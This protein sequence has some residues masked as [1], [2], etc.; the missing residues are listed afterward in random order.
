MN[1][2]KILL[3]PILG[4]IYF[5]FVFVSDYQKIIDVLQQ[6]DLLYVFFAVISWCVS[7][8]CRGLRWHSFMSVITGKI[9]F[10]KNM[11]YYF[12]GLTMILTPGRLGEIIRCNFIKKDY[13]IP[14]SKTIALMFVE[15]FYELFIISITISV[16][17][18]STEISKYLIILPVTI[19]VF[20]LTIQSKKLFLKILYKFNKFNFLKNITSNLEQ[21]F[22]IMNLLTRP[23]HFWKGTILTILIIIT[24]VF[25]VFLLFKA[26]NA[27]INFIYLIGIFQTS[28]ILAIISMIPLGLGVWEGSFISLLKINGISEELGISVALFTRIISISTAICFGIIGLR[29]ITKNHK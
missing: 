3:V 21:V 6:I 13:Q 5:V 7:I 20:L 25:G 16:A 27:E 26:F 1:Y 28:Q 8:I 9:S 15:R 22:E 18:F 2:K 29:L 19:I 17:V 14:I 10:K 12:L 23:N 4:I 24:E 11:M